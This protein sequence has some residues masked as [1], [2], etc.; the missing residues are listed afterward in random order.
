[1][2]GLRE[3]AQATGNRAAGKAARRTAELFLEHRIFRQLGSGEPIHPSMVKLH[4]PPYWHY[5]VLQALHLLARIGLV[6]DKRCGD[7][8]DL[9][10]RR[11]LPDG[12]WRP[13]AYWWS[14][15]G[16]A[17]AP[18]AVDW[19]R[20]GPSEMLTLNALRVLRAAGRVD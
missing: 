13:G 6:R 11:R 16:S 5:D 12:R 2:W 17:R 18:E 19:G 3:Y 14:L 20:S 8:V 7:A 4:Y 10:E 1:M 15:P 9:L